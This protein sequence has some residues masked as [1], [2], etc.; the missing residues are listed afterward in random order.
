MKRT[1]IFLDATLLRR[2]HEFARR[3]GKSF[4]SVVREALA[5]YIATPGKSQSR[6]PS[7]AGSFASG[8][9]DTSERVNELLWP[10][11]DR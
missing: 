7:V 8:R 2:A 3:E 10:E 4:A 1:S 9:S 6:L 5:L 11:P